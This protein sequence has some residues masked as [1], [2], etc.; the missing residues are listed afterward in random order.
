M[1]ELKVPIMVEQR[2]AMMNVFWMGR[3]AREYIKYANVS[4]QGAECT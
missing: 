3:L 1:D 4:G 2:V